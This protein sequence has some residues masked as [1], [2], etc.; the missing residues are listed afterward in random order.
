MARKVVTPNTLLQQARCACRSPSRP[1]T[2]MSRSELATV[3][4]NLLHHEGVLDADIDAG[5]VGKLEAGE[6]RWPRSP[7][8][9]WALRTA[10]RVSSGFRSGRRDPG[11][12][13]V[14]SRQASRSR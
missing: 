10:L 9:R 11:T 6:Y 3:V 7:H 5:Y 4:N 1:G 12:R 14:R 2:H 13:A 8:R